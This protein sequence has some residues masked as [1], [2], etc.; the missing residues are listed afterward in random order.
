MLLGNKADL[1]ERAISEETVVGWMNQFH[2]RFHFL[3]S[4][5]TK[6]NLEKAFEVFAELLAAPPDGVSKLRINAVDLELKQ[7]SCC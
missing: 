4:A 3:V 1:P 6:E 5:K 7:N 2:I